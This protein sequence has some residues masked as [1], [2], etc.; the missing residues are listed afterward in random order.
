V[1][2]FSAISFTTLDFY[3]EYMTTKFIKICKIANNAC[4]KC[5]CSTE[6]Y[7]STIVL[8]LSGI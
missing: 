3:L 1:I 7:L 5:M 4:G 6:I 8:Y 2:V